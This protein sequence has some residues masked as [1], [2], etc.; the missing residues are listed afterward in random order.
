MSGESYRLKGLHTPENLINTLQVQQGSHF[1][2]LHTPE[3]FIYVIVWPGQFNLNIL[4]K[5]YLA[6]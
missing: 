3:K 1:I 2:G 4:I 5:H 6:A